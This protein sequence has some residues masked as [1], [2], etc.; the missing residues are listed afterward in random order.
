MK[1]KDEIIDAIRTK[2]LDHNFAGEIPDDRFGD[3]V[4]GTFGGYITDEEQNAIDAI[5]DDDERDDALVEALDV[6]AVGFVRY[7]TGIYGIEI[8][9]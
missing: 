9:E 3:H 4:V 8:A 5:E 6:I 7:L 1:T 2:W